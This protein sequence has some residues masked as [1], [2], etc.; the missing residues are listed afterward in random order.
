[1]LLPP[2]ILAS[3]L[4]PSGPP[5]PT[6]TGDPLHQEAL[7]HLLEAALR[8]TESFGPLPDMPWR[9]QLHSEDSTFEA[10]TGAPGLRSACW[11]GDTLHLRP[12]ERLQ[13]RDLPALLRHECVHRRCLDRGLPRWQEEA[14]CLWAEGH[15]HPPNPLPEAPS[16]GLQTRLDSCLEKGTTASQAWAYAWLRA[17]L[18][19][20]PLPP[21]PP[22]RPASPDPWHSAHPVTVVWPPERLPRNLTV[23]GSPL[24]W[25]LGESHLYTGPVTFGAPFPVSGLEGRCQL[26]AVPKGWRLSWTTDPDSWLAAATEGELGAEAPLEA[27][28]A[29]AAVLRVWLRGP[30]HPDGSLCPLTHCAV[31][32][33]QPSTPGI[34]AARN[35]PDWPLKSEQARFTG[36]TG[37]HPLSPREVWGAAEARR[38]RTLPEVP[39]DPWA[40]WTRRLSPAQVRSLKRAVKPGLR[41]GQLGLR[42][43]PSGPYAIE[44]LRLEAGR[45]FG[46]T[47]WPSNACTASLHPDG[48]LLLEGHGWGHNVGLDLTLAIQRARE[49]ATAETILEEAFG[50]E[51]GMAPAP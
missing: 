40:S 50:G 27:K 3:V 46:W 41:Q 9:V 43:G 38:P 8:S 51:A 49:G 20:A 15:T 28:R 47:L 36:S 37:G 22:P 31:I 48:S 30:H 32:R 34:E 35:A 26:E 24:A 14:L 45:R 13:R 17:W 25:H 39:A 33:G 4:I 18:A 11:V 29:L 16:P 10:A 21:P 6:L 7:S 5:A 19:R 42:L 23:N 2:L 1:M 44:S 12:W